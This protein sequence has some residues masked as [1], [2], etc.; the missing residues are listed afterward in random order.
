[1]D[2]LKH[3]ELVKS[4]L[5][6]LILVLVVVGGFF[7]YKGVSGS[8]EYQYTEYHDYFDLEEDEKNEQYIVKVY[9]GETEIFI[10]PFDELRIVKDQYKTGCALELNVYK[11]LV[12]GKESIGEVVLYYF[13]SNNLKEVN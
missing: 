10:I 5:G 13:I 7:I 1:M 6:V 3:N 9:R 4:L 8:R 2:K 12:D 11:N